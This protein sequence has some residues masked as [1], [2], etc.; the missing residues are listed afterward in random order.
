MDLRLLGLLA[1]VQ[2]LSAVENGCPP[3][4]VADGYFV[5]E[6]N[7]FPDDIQLSY[8]CNTGFKPATIGWWATIT[9]QNGKW[10]SAPL[11]INETSCFVPQIPNADWNKMAED[12]DKA[13][14]K[15]NPGYEN[16]ISAVACCEKG[17]WKNLPVCERLDYWCG[18]PPQIPKAVIIN[19]VYKDM[20]QEQDEVEYVCQTGFKREGPVKAKCSTGKWI[21]LPSCSK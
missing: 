17:E 6:Q 3:P 15:C 10:S 9:C 7:D 5:S 13:W 21:D 16:K 20:F 12:G 2:C 19:Q 8:A 4:I 14:I 11:C 1:V 18:L